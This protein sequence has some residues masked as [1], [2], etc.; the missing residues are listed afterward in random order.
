[1]ADFALLSLPSVNDEHEVTKL[2]V[3][4]ECP[5]AGLRAGRKKRSIIRPDC[6]RRLECDNGLV[7][8]L[9]R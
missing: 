4:G 1:M 6:L 8:L 5:Q 3:E 2:H 9:L 7:E